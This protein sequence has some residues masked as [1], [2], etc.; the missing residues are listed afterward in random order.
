MSLAAELADSAA[1]FQPSNAQIR[2]RPLKIPLLPVTL[3]N[4]ALCHLMYT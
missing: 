1:S 2:T 4:L 3:P